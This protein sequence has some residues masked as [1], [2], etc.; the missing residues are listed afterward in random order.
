MTPCSYFA[1]AMAWSLVGL[2]AGIPIG[3][4]IRL[5]R[6]HNMLR[7]E[8][9]RNRTSRQLVFGIVLL[10]LAVLSLVQGF[11]TQRCLN[12]YVSTSSTVQKLRSGLV[13]KE[14]TATRDIIRGAFTAQSKGDAIA[15]YAKYQEALARIDSAR[16]A[17]PVTEFRGCGGWFR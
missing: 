12:D 3:Y 7:F 9:F 4:L 14:S 17:N 16:D 6:E 1:H 13:E 8:K 11:R 10:L 5:G 15:A 2:L